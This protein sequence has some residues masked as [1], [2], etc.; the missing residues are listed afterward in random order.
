MCTYNKTAQCEPERFYKFKAAENC[1]SC[2]YALVHLQ[3]PV[4]TENDMLTTL[5]Y[6]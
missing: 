2:L 3:Q 1:F 4:Y 6:L 5:Y